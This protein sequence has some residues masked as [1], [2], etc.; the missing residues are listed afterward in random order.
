[1]REFKLK[2]VYSTHFKVA[3]HKNA[4]VVDLWERGGGK[5]E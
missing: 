2:D 1:M 5:G 3:S 4:T